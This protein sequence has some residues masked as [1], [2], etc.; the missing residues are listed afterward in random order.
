MSF[1]SKAQEFYQIHLQEKFGEPRGCSE[2]E[3]REIERKFGHKLPAAYEEFLRWM[4]NDTNGVFR[5]SDWFAKDI[6]DNTN[7]V[8]ELLA[9]NGIAWHHRRPILSFFCHQGYMIAWF[10]FSPSNDDPP[11]HFFSEGKNMSQPEQR[12]TFSEFLENEL[13]GIVAAQGPSD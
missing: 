12:E 6:V 8:S 4:G 5:G 9:T 11:C 1:L 2:E 10:E 13:A 3:I 7:Y